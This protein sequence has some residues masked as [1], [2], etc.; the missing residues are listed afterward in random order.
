M[1]KRLG[2]IVPSSNTTM[3]TEFWELARLFNETQEKSA[4]SITLNSFFG[5]MAL[6]KVTLSALKEMEKESLF[7]AEK[8]AHAQVDLICYGCTSGSFIEGR[9]MSGGITEKLTK[10]TQ[11]QSYTTAQ[12]IS[13][14]AHELIDTSLSVITPYTDEINIREKEFLEAKG[15]KVDQIKGMGLV[16]NTSI[17]RVQPEEL[18]KFVLN[19]RMQNSD[20]LF[21]SCT[22]LPTLLSIIP[23]TEK[24]KMT[25]FSSN[26]ASFWLGLKKM[27]LLNQAQNT[28]LA[29]LLAI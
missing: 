22:N 3:E 2:V 26:T 12:A 11:I 29:K 16:E 9:D 1:I 21:I 10:T 25:V 13:E 4:N 23:L 27:N 5:R 14:L 17:G 24:L 8:L 15:I 18:E 7:E 20:A 19:S 28:P 6:K